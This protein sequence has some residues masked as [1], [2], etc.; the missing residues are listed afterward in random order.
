MTHE[1]TR[2]FVVHM[3]KTAGTTLRDRLRNHFPEAAIYPNR[4][5]GP[6]KGH[7]VISVRHLLE[8][9]QARGSDIR[10]LTGHFPLSTIELLDGPFVT[11][12][13]LRP[14]VERTLSYLRHQRK[15]G[16]AGPR[17]DPESHGAHAVVDRRRDEGR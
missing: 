11:L 2:F 4:T 6:D 14:P 8:R 10:L 3:Q 1:H 7:A 17:A 16:K 12:T 5:D 15:I 13:V 9:W